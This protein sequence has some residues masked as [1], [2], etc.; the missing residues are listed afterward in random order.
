MATMN[1]STCPVDEPTVPAV[2]HHAQE[3]NDHFSPKHWRFIR[4]RSS[5]RLAGA[6]VI[7][8]AVLP[9]TADARMSGAYDGVWSVVLATTRG[10]CGSRYSVPFTVAGG[11][12]SSA[13]GGRVSGSVAGNGRVAVDVSVGASKA[14]GGARLA[15]NG[16]AGSWSGIISGDRRSGTWQA[17]RT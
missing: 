6:F 11:H 12:V 10:K 3:E 8:M 16:G 15:G 7:T 17:S 14:S 13:G 4:F 9:S 1:R 2:R 5:A